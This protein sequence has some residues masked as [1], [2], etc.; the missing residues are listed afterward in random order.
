[1]AGDLPMTCYWRFFGAMA[2]VGCAFLILLLAYERWPVSRDCPVVGRWCAGS[3]SNPLGNDVWIEYGPG[4]SSAVTIYR[5]FDGDGLVDECL[6][7][8]GVNI[9]VF[10]AQNSDG[11]LDT[12]RNIRQ[13]WDAADSVERVPKGAPESGPFTRAELDEKVR[14]YPREQR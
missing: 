4:V 8:L 3:I 9:T 13:P 7:I 5:D 10:R 1:M 2:V 6:M 11:I 14:L 12:M